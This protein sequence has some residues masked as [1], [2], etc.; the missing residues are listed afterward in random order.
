VNGALGGLANT[1][2]N[3]PHSLVHGAF[4]LANR[5]VHAAE[6]GPAPALPAPLQKFED[7]LHVEAPPETQQ[8]GETISHL[9]PV[10][11]VHGALSD[12]DAAIA[13][14]SPT[15]SRAIDAVGSVGNDILNVAPAGGL[16]RGAAGALDAAA[17]RTAAGPV[18]QNNWQQLG[19][20]SGLEHPQAQAVAGSSGKQALILHNQ[21]IGNT[22]ASAEAGVPHGQPLNYDT[23]EAA[24]AAPNTVYERVSAM[25]PAGPLSPEAANLVRAAGGGAERITAGSPNA[26]AQIAANRERL[27]QPGIRFTGDQV[28]NEMRGLRQEGYTN[29]G[30][31]DISN[32]QLGRAQLDMARALEQHVADTIPPNA[33]ISME[34]LQAA[35]TALAKNH[36]VQSALRG[37]NVDM[38]SLARIQR[39][40]PQILTGGLQ[41][42]ADFANEHPTVSTLGSKQYEPPSYTKDVLGRGL[43]P[44]LLSP[45]YFAGLFGGQ[46]G[47][48]KILIGSTAD[49]V[50]AAR[51]RLPGR[52]GD[53]FAPLPPGPL[54]LQPPPGQVFEPV[55]HDMLP[56]AVDETKAA[57]M[58]PAPR[59][60]DLEPPLGN[61]FEAGQRELFDGGVVPG[62]D[63][64][65]EK[66]PAAPAPKPEPKA[67]G[68]KPTPRETLGDE[69]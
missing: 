2:L 11:A 21:Q 49:A 25:L 23:L 9:A 35:R 37:S 36:A 26:E 24:R 5:A 28:V 62:R 69:F 56:A 6:P 10:Q 68:K 16:I 66:P 53:E 64:P 44:D 7:M 58:Q 39:V 29:I 20:R 15:A 45:R 3:I 18:S 13:R 52:L 42:T 22:A 31:D 67:K 65:Y 57:V 4:D 60:F 41:A 1:V 38:Q 55:Q 34:Q 43:S 12:A 40:D 59:Q 8:L 54:Q 47:A 19:F 63:M 50:A 33:N 30:S 14:A 61:V 17:A 32:Q 51:G 27:L 46:A 48:R